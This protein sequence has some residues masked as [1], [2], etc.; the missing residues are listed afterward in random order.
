[1]TGLALASLRHR[2]TASTATFLAILLGTALMGSFASL[3]AAAAGPVSE[4]DR[5]ALI[6]M[7]SVVGGWGSLIVLFAVI[8]TVGITATQ[9][10]VEI[11]VLRTIG[12]TPRQA[13]RLIRAETLVVALVASGAGALLA[14]LG[15]RA[16]LAALRSGGLVAD[17]VRVDGE[18]VTHALTAVIVVTLSLLASEIAGRRAARGPATV[19]PRESVPGGRRPRWWRAV[20]G[21]I[22]VGYGLALGVI[23]VTVTADAADPYDAMGTSGPASI[24]VG[25]GLAALAPWLLR[26][27]APL[28]RPLLLLAGPAGRLAADN[29]RRRASL[30]SGVL[31]PVIVLTSA[32]MGTLTLVGIDG[33]TL[34]ASGFDP[35]VADQ[36]NLL[37]NVVV[38]MI[39]LF[40]AVVVVNSFAAVLAHRTAELRRLW[41]IGATPREIRSSVVAEAALV[42]GVG[43][44]LG[45]LAALATTVPFGIARHEG[46]IPNGQLWLPPLV[47][48]GA[49][50]LTLL[51]ARLGLR[52]SGPVAT[53]APSSR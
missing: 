12:A 35:A 6:T 14:A 18:L 27:L 32:A 36:I 40:A 2:A 9:R 15:G 4:P 42:A 51:A 17:S 39:V 19:A 20:A 13:R 16:L 29:A 8:S 49:V 3:F 24:V 47:A 45:T 11:G 10:E 26:L 34:P 23:T 37:N 53:P 31:A 43:V 38:A 30:L 48:V 44:V 21:V 33:R 5:E 22:L 28:G 50:I 7:G 46:L 41:L 52:W 1:M 25:L